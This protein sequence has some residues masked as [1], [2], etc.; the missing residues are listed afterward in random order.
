[1]SNERGHDKADGSRLP[2]R[3]SGPLQLVHAVD[4]LPS[5]GEREYGYFFNYYLEEFFT[6]FQTVDPDSFRNVVEALYLTRGRSQIFTAGN[7]GSS[8]TAEH[9]YHN[10]NWDTSAKL[11]FGN[12]LS[13]RCLSSEISEMTGRGNDRDYAYSLATMLENHAHSGDVF[14]GISASGTSDNI[15]KA[16]ARARGFGLTAIFIGKSNS[17]LAEQAD[18]S[19][20]VDSDDQ[21]ILEDVSQSVIHMLV[22]ALRVKLAGLGESS[23]FEDIAHLRDKV[24]G[25][26]DLA[27]QLGKPT[28]RAARAK[29]EFTH[30]LDTYVEGRIA[31]AARKIFPGQELSIESLGS[32]FTSFVRCVRV[33]YQKAL[34]K[35]SLGKT[36][37][38]LIH[39]R[40]AQ[41]I[42]GF[43]EV[44]S[45]ESIDVID[46][47][48]RTTY[49]SS[50]F[51]KNIPQPWDLI[52]GVA[53]YAFIEGKTLE[54]TMLDGGLFPMAR[55]GRLLR[56]WHDFFRT[57]EPPEAVRQ[58]CRGSL[59]RMDRYETRYMTAE[60]IEKAFQP[61]L[62]NGYVD[63][64]SYDVIAGLLMDIASRVRQSEVL[65]LARDT[66]GHGDFK[67]ENVMLADHG[68]IILLDNDLHKKPAIIDVA[69]MISRSLALCFDGQ[70]DPDKITA[71]LLEFIAGYTTEWEMPPYL[72]RIIAMDLVT[73]LAGYATINQELLNES[74]LLAQLFLARPRAIVDFA[75]YLTAREHPSLSSVADYFH[76]ATIVR[77]IR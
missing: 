55:L 11:P 59:D 67:P 15:I 45:M 25:T 63:Q 62:Q 19:V 76:R 58:S 6:A 74:A 14:I 36:R 34:A 24:M 30:A 56:D 3:V 47:Y 72:P 51:P 69:K 32:D 21:Q 46:E 77:L 68:G 10:L 5:L 23:L 60:G 49:L 71:A 7:G 20:T 73:I 38:R 64:K 4:F 53:F 22:R 27:E 29:I 41:G 13:A 12:K 35:F 70:Q 52:D 33:G 37:A 39:D 54:Q 57:S 61:L 18:V 31:R 16:L 1:M 2:A 48:H 9:L 75:D 42:L 8:T 65:A 66:W 26:A 50:I 44:A 40:S 17:P 43:A 28:D